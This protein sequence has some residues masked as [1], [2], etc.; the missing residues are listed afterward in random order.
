MIKSL[1]ADPVSE[2]RQQMDCMQHLLMVV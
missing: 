1:F 2:C